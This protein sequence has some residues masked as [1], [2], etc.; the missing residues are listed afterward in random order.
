M[1]R[2]L[3]LEMCRET[4][5]IK[6]EIGG[7]RKVPNRLRVNYKGEEYYPVAYQLGFGTDGGAT[8]TA[9]LHE[10]CTNTIWYAALDKVEQKER[11]D[12]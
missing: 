6:P 5:V 2:K 9:I 3:Y 11:N 7:I 12:K 8:H 4:A 1:D 10:I